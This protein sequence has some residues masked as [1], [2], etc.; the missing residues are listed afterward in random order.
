MLGNALGFTVSTTGPKSQRS[1]RSFGIDLTGAQVEEAAF[2]GA[3]AAI[4]GYWLTF[5]GSAEKDATGAPL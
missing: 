1:Q 2:S 5:R 4:A 3:P